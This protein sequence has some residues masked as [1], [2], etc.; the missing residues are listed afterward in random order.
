MAEGRYRLDEL[1]WLQFQ[2]L[3]AAAVA[4]DTGIGEESWTG[5]ADSRRDTVLPGGVPGLLTGPTL[6]SVLWLRHQIPAKRRRAACLGRVDGVRDAF[7]ARARDGTRAV[8]VLLM[9]NA[10]HVLDEGM[11][12]AMLGDL[13]DPAAVAVLGTTELSGGLD[14]SPGLRRR[15]PATLGTTD[16]SRLVPEKAG[17]ASSFDRAAA[18]ELARVF[19][20]TRSYRRAVGS[21]ERHGFVVLTGPPEVG[22][23]AIAQM[24]ALVQLT[25]G[26]EAHDCRHPDELFSRYRASVPQIFL[27]D[28]AFGS[29][30]YRPDAAER[31]A[32]ELDRVLARMDETHWLVWTS[33][34][35]PL[36]AGLRRVHRERGLERFPDPGSVQ[37]D[38]SRLGVE[39]KVLILF[40]HARAAGL[41]PDRRRFVQDHG[42]GIVAHR[43]F[44]P[45][46][47]RRLARGLQGASLDGTWW[48][49]ALRHP[50]EAMSS[51]LAALEDEH[52]DLL[53]ALLDAPPSWVSE[54]DLTRALRRHHPGGLTHA[55]HELIDRLADHFLRVNDGGIGWVHPSWRDL[56]IRD[57]AGDPP[58]RS[59][60]L[61]VAG[62]DG[63]ELAVS[64]G[65]G[66]RGQRNLPLAVDDAD[67]DVLTT[68][69]LE[70]ARE[71]D[72][73]GVARLLRAVTEAARHAH[74]DWRR[75]EA[76]VL[77]REALEATLPRL[78]ESELS[79][80]LLEAW[81]EAA[82]VLSDEAPE[83]PRFT[84]AWARLLPAGPFDDPEEV[85]RASDWLALADILERYLPLDLYDLG[86]P[87]R[88]EDLL[89]A[90]SASGDPRLTQ[91]A[92]G[93]AG[94]TG[95]APYEPDDERDMAPEPDPLPTGPVSVASV[96]R[97][98]G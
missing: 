90:M 85:A 96:L 4:E 89:N 62:I 18:E 55:P 74:G 43:Y 40:R 77:T 50:T 1:G 37:V 83:P 56:V 46:R 27:A 69:T 97:D 38:A 59:R 94:V 21:L 98:L 49:D 41:D 57:I 12:P 60:F 31:W 19:V 9:T 15:M 11:L 7:Q 6:A 48:D 95:W 63:V 47:I 26:W 64:V 3:C 68:R 67:W 10:A 22:K 86:F 70:L 73:E 17:A 44:T 87:D 76:A 65:G 51:S 33:R 54:R 2:E 80:P 23:T 88:Y 45:E 58:G 16:V 42:E 79:L 92:R 30:E 84:H 78:E 25:D 28:D 66:A 36:A 5:T 8:S 72:S 81:L 24:L 14:A 32:R 61:R 93:R 75:R 20:A 52:R 35:A 13:V 71:L 53:V 82:E 39:E 29:T 34:P 91:L